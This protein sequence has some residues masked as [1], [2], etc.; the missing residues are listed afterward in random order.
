MLS[1]VV[2]EPP[3]RPLGRVVSAGVEKGRLK[4]GVVG[5]DS[6]SSSV[7]LVSHMVSW[8]IEKCQ[9]IYVTYPF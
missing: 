9:E 4:Y 3:L 5:D 1:G 6:R 8:L 7:A 2:P